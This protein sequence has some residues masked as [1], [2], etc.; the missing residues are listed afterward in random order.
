LIFQV[1]I[2]FLLD[3]SE[4]AS[5]PT[6]HFYTTIECGAALLSCNEPWNEPNS[7]ATENHPEAA[8]PPSRPVNLIAA[9]VHFKLNSCCD[10]SASGSPNAIVRSLLPRDMPIMYW[11]RSDIGT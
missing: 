6:S 4:K 10:F 1:S 9:A 5:Q 2:L 11:F 8:T 7:I 3:S